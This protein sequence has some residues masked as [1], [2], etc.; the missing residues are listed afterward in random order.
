MPPIEQK[1]KTVTDLTLRSWLN[2]G[3][4][5]RSVG[6]DLMFVASEASSRS[7]RASWILCYR[8]GGRQKEKVLGRYPDISLKEAR[9]IALPDR[10]LIQQGVDVAALKRREKLK[11]RETHS[12]SSLARLWYER[13][14]EK[15]LE[16]NPAYGFSTF[17]AGWH[18]EC[19]KPMAHHKRVGWRAAVSMATA[20]SRWTCATWLSTAASIAWRDCSSSKVCAR[21]Q[22]TAAGL[23]LRG[24][25]P[26]VVAP[27]HLQRQLKVA[28]RNPSW[29]TDITYIRTHE[30][31]LY[32]AVVVT[33]FAR[34]VVGW[35]MGS[36]IGTSLILD[37]LLM[38][39][40]RRQP[41]APVLVH[42]GQGCQFT[43]HEWQ[44]FLR[45]HNLVGSMSRRGSAVIHRQQD[46]HL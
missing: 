4:V 10:A 11:A 15:W 43:G 46:S 32:L 8:F 9:D 38:A 29:V 34:Q 36:R 35:P 14:I 41:R 2:A 12:V 20:S 44:T 24:G 21:R 25:K 13:E 33:L 37:A 39:L 40:C 27:N 6:N 26:A 19:Q 23:G 28:Q 3:P 17:D 1:T 42:S 30:G 18:R 7:G 5:D 31:W 16:M 22:A 45:D